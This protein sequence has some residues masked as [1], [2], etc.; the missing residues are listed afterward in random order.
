MQKTVS[1]CRVIHVPTSK[2]MIYGFKKNICISEGG[3]PESRERKG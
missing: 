2:L 1:S 3:P